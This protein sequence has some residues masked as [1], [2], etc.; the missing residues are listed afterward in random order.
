MRL[1]RLPVLAVV[2]AR[3]PS[4]RLGRGRKASSLSSVVGHRAEV[5]LADA[6]LLLNGQVAHDERL[7]HCDPKLLDG[8]RKGM[9]QT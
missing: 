4:I 6:T 8:M 7:R 9:P 3:C 1:V 5:N 2:E